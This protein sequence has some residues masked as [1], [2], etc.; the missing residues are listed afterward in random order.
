MN[1][2]SERLDVVRLD[3]RD[4]AEYLQHL[5]EQFD[6]AFDA[7]CTLQMTV[8]ELKILSDRLETVMHD[9]PKPK[10]TRRRVAVRRGPVKK[11]TE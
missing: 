5:L 2:L 9:L 3:I 1:G 10:K 6:V 4:Q 11:P 8:A 7:C